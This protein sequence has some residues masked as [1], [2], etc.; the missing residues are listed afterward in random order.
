MK[1]DR[2]MKIKNNTHFN[3]FQIKTF[4]RKCVKQA[5]RDGESDCTKY[6]TVEIG[7]S[8][9]NYSGYAY[10]NG[11]YMYLRVPK[12]QELDKRLF[13]FIVLHE[14]DHILGYRHKVMGRHNIDTYDFS[15]AKK[16]A[17]VQKTQTQGI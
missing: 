10:I 6:L 14:Y 7:Y 13:A 17:P 8:H 11:T 2:I 1:N 4:I 5:I 3:T 9:G 12:I 16:L 15:F